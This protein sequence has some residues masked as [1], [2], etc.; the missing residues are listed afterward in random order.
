MFSDT[1]Y[2][3][4]MQYTIYYLTGLLSFIKPLVVLNKHYKIIH[5]FP[6]KIKY[7]EL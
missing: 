4:L 2:Y 7:L 3:Y 6:K 5:V 1:Q